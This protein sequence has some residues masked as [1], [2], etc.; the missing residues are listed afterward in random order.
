MS[1]VQRLRQSG[2]GMF[3]TTPH[4][5]IECGGAGGGC[6]PLR[7]L[8][9][10]HFQSWGYRDDAPR[11][12]SRLYQSCGGRG[13]RCPWSTATRPYARRSRLLAPRRRA[14]RLH[15][16][17]RRPD[18]DVAVVLSRLPVPIAANGSRVAA[19]R[20]QNPVS[21]WRSTAAARAAKRRASSSPI[22]VAARR[23][24]RVCPRG[25]HADRR[26]RRLMRVPYR[27]GGDSKV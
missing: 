14:V 26:R 9:A 10:P 12:P 5:P 15:A 23:P 24:R 16:R 6:P 27:P 18:D 20:R 22:A 8:S 17:H 7:H 1:A 19:R 4:T 25:R 13:G 21:A 3:R 2:A 11:E